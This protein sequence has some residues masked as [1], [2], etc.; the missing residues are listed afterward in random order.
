MFALPDD[1]R[2]QSTFIEFNYNVSFRG[3]KQATRLTNNSNKEKKVITTNE[4]KERGSAP[5]FSRRFDVKRVKSLQKKT[6]YSSKK[7]KKTYPR[8]SGRDEGLPPNFSILRRIA[9][10][11]SRVCKK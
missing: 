2:V 8:I 5:N 1:Y 9:V 7:E 4:W 3:E 11:K 10:K 6:H